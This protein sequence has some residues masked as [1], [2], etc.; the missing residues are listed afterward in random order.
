MDRSTP[1]NEISRFTD[2][3]LKVFFTLFCVLVLSTGQLTAAPAGADPQKN[4]TDGSAGSSETMTIGLR[5]FLRLVLDKNER[6]AFQ[7]AELAIS[8]EG[9]KAA[10]AIFEPALVNSF[11]YQEDRRRNTLQE[12]VSQG[13][14][15]EFHERSRNWQAAVEGLLPTGARVRMGY[16][17]KDFSNSIEDKYGADQEAQTVFGVSITQPLLKGGGLKATMAGIETAKADSDIALQNYRAQA[18]RVV[19]EATA[20][21]WDLYLAREKHRIRKE[22]EENASKIL[23]ENLLRVKSGKMAE[24]EVL[25]AEAALALRSSLVS[26]SRQNIVSALNRLRGY[27]SSSALGEVDIQ[28]AEQLQYSEIR[29]DFVQSVS[30][31]FKSRAD[32][33]A[34]LKKIEREDVRLVFAENQRWPQLDLKGSYNMNGLTDS[35]KSSW[36]DAWERDYKTWY[37]G[38]ELRIPLAGDRKGKSELEAARQRKK[39][40]LLELK[41]MEVSLANDTDT[42]IRGVGNAAEQV[43]Q[44]T[45]IVDKNRKL[46]DAEYR[47]FQ[48]GKSNSRLLLEREEELNRAREAEVDSLVRHRKSIL[49]L[50]M[51]EGSVL[52][53]QCIE[54]K[55]ENYK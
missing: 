1:Q 21:Y 55:G 29:P 42:A 46:L 38:V 11:N 27:I 54:I 6:I 52:A 19:A 41:A 43:R 9:V 2:H 22:S 8:R 34:T 39:Q 25:E 3:F 5:D 37:I 47:K 53:S 13:N 20:S 7:G 33:Q 10:E 49:Q 45:G 35:P 30:K 50:E 14:S 17:L 40:A 18:M 28:P 26:D 36:S 23:K 16:T 31:A 4:R 51:A 12:F 48:A 24:T 32:Y 44:Y 15:A